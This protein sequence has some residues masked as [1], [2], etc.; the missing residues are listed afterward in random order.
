MGGF[1]GSAHVRGDDPRPVCEALEPV[2]RT[3]KTRFFVGPPLNGWIGIYP[4][5]N[6]QNTAPARAVARRLGAEVIAMVAHDE[7]IFVYEY[8]SGGKRIDQ[9]NSAPEYWG[10]I[11]EKAKHK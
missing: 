1:Y 10:P 6:G 11:S 3:H 2:A 5:G 9:F 4:D 8:Y 7:D